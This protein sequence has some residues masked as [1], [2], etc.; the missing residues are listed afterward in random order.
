M[1]K[2]TR[3]IKPAAKIDATIRLPGSK[4]ITHRALM[5]AS[6]A[7]G[8]ST[9]RAPLDA[10]DTRLTAGALEQLGTGIDW[11]EDSILVTPAARRWISP[12]G[13]IFLGNSGTSTR[14][15]LPL[16][17]AG[18][19]TFVLDGTARLRDRPVGP[20]ADALETLGTRFRWLGKPGYP[21]VEITGAGFSGGE[22]TVDASESSQFLSGL[23]LAA[24]TAR[25]DVR[26]TWREPVASFPYVA[27]T[28]AMMER[29]GIRFERP[30][31]NAVIVPA[32]RAYAP[33]D[34]TVEGDCS[35]ASYF[36]GAAAVTGGAVFTFPVSSESL[37]GDSRFLGVLEKMGCRIE[38][39]GE[40][41]R[42]IGP[43]RLDP[44]DIDM[45]RMPDM[46][47]TLAV[48]AAF[49]PGTSRIRNVAHLRI[50]ESDRLESV[51]AGLAALGVRVEQLRDGLIIHG[52][53]PAPPSRP[54][55]A[56]DDHRIAMAFALA[57]LR[58]DGVVIDGAESVAKS[59]PEFWEYFER[60]GAS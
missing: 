21:P 4:S 20:V 23:L 54:I 52:G 30:A 7:S 17:S 39:E 14:L 43:A 11:R 36:W 6:L 38:W 48:L 35:S 34:I 29:A 57:G 47:P 53:N 19:G 58:I 2:L 12:A 28:L 41:V 56:F 42:V 51:A 5:M 8:P 1:K 55:S 45:N 13:P 60:L 50:K 24:P 49:A 37:Q 44:I 59:F 33:L 3:K 40:G 22:V 15:L 9:I 27:M 26:I 31:P 10:E 46:A 16:A 32:P 18:T 25:K